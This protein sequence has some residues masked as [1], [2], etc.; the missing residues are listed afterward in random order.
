MGKMWIEKDL[1]MV[2]QKMESIK[3][4]DNNNAEE[5][6]KMEDKDDKGSD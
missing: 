1:I 4:E 5:K 6:S 2:L 3:S